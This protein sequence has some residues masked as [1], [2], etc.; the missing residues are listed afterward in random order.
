MKSN[1]S[2]EL[3]TKSLVELKALAD[4]SR[5]ELFNLSFNHY[6][7]QLADVASIKVT[8]RNIARIETIIRERELAGSEG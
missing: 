7:G 1:K 8:R 3:R 2:S 6:T 5:K 4:D